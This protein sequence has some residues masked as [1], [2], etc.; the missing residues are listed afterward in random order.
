MGGVEHSE[1]AGIYKINDEVAIVQTVDFFTPVVDDPRIFGQ[2]AAANAL[3]DVYAMGGVP[4]TA[5]N[6][7]PD[8]GRTLN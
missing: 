3:S 4:I 8:Q 6:G 2:V 7:A 1:D 5:M